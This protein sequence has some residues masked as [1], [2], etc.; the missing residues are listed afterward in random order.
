M[1]NLSWD[2]TGGK[3]EVAKREE[4]VDDGKVIITMGIY[5]HSVDGKVPV[6]D[7]VESAEAY[8]EENISGYGSEETDPKVEIESFYD[9]EFDESTIL[10]MS[11]V[12][13]IVSA[14][15]A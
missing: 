3:I 7:D 9:Y 14:V 5:F 10:M 15:E 8:A 6:F 13:K 2:P 11:D 4:I 12:T 1:K